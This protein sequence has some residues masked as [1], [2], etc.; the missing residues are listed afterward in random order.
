M[1]GFVFPVAGKSFSDTWNG[2]PDVCHGLAE[3]GS[4]VPDVWNGF[5]EVCREF[6]DVRFGLTVTGKDFSVH[7][8]GFSDIGFG[9]S[10]NDPGESMKGGA[11][12]V[13]GWGVG[14]RGGELLELTP[15]RGLCSRRLRPGVLQRRPYF[16]GAAFMSTSI[17]KRASV[18]LTLASPLT[19]FLW[20]AFSTLLLSSIFKC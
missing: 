3:I 9:F 2:I 15:V 18:I 4:G 5:P 7:G 12:S 19:A 10:V 14:N 13:N 17:C 1:T 16:P 8:F 6:P 20:L 11:G